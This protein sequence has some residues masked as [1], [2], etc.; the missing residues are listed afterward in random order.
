MELPLRI[1]LRFDDYKSTV[2]PLNYGSKCLSVQTVKR[3]SALLTT[4]TKEYNE[5]FGIGINFTSS[6]STILL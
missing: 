1:E 4:K 2:L 5:R 3:L 6:Y